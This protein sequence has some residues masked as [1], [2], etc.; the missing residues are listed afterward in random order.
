MLRCLAL[1]SL[2][3][4]A[5]EMILMARLVHIPHAERIT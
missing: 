4:P 1:W 3:R 2:V 5:K